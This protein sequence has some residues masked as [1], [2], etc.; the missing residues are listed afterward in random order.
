MTLDVKARPDVDALRAL[1]NEWQPSVHG[2]LTDAHVYL[3]EKS[4]RG[5]DIATIVAALLALLD[6]LERAEAKLLETA[7]TCDD[8]ERGY[9]DDDMS[10]GDLAREM[11][12][13]SD[14]LRGVAALDDEA[15]R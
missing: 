12:A 13:I 14:D 2:S 3:G 15:P 4:Y 7:S 1:L 6:R 8:L 9:L 10:A 11:R 5:A